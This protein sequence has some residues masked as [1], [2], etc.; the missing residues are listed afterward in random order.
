MISLVNLRLFQSKL[1]L[2]NNTLYRKYS[3]LGPDYVLPATSFIS[4]KLSEP[5]NLRFNYKNGELKKFSPISFY[6]IFKER[7][8]KTPNHIA[9]GNSNDYFNN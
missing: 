4:T 6:T 7:A 3:Y 1:I 8:E 2:K 9:M 5:V